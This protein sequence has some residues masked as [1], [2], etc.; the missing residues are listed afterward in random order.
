MSVAGAATRDDVS[1]GTSL[2]KVACHPRAFPSDV[3]AA[4]A[5]PAPPGGLGRPADDLFA[6][7]WSGNQAARRLGRVLIF[8][9]RN[10]ATSRNCRVVTGCAWVVTG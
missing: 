6:P 5:T 3:D 7:G 2:F 10:A 1:R 4:R 8:E 9:C